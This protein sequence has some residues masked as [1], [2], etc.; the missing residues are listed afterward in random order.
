M[1]FQEVFKKYNRRIYFLLL[2][3]TRNAEEA[4]DL[5]QETFIKCYKKLHSFRKESKLYTWL[6]RI[7]I[8]CWKNKV[9]YNKRRGIY[10]EV[11]LEEIERFS[12][13]N[14]TGKILNKNY[15]S[16]ESFV[17][18]LEKKQYILK[19]VYDLDI[20]YRIPI[21]LYMEGYSINEI[22]H[23]IKKRISTVKS[24]IFRV[25]FKLKDKLLKYKK[26]S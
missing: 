19:C 26:R 3:L 14:S 12:P 2:S 8:N 16:S 5:T 13:V 17:K 18:D 22:S 9:R 23:I 4:E 24:L 11:S 10:K 25:K 15:L 6:H 7:A 21:I 1:K 20:K